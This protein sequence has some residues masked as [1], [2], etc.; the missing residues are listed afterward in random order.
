MKTRSDFKV[1]FLDLRIDDPL[2]RDRLMDAINTVFEHGRFILGPEVTELENRVAHYCD[3]KFA[4]GLGSGT[5]AVLLALRAHEVGP[6]DEV[7]TSA[8]SW[9]ATGT[10]IAQTGATPVFTDVGNDLVMDAISIEPLMS[11]RTKAIVPVHYTGKVCDM[12]AISRIAVRYGIPVIEDASQAFGARRFGRPAGSFG[13]MAAFSLNPM[14]VFA[15]CGEAGILLTDDAQLATTVRALRYNGMVDADTT[16]YISGNARIDTL[17]AAILLK[18][19]DSVSHHIERRRT[20]ARE[21][22]SAFKKFFEV[23]EEGDEIADRDA[24]YTYTVRTDAREDLYIHLQTNGVEAKIRDRYLL[25]DQPVFHGNTSGSFP[26]A[27]RL[28]DTLLC[29]P[30]HDKMTDDDASFVI[31]AVTSFFE[32]GVR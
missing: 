29:L 22:N 17:Q 20:I 28:I 14:K 7:I 25:S 11:E 32:D 5:D 1:P 31:S 6:G 30:L 21:Y 9:L 26:N 16:R 2:E 12:A 27:R 18:R 8:L 3:R 10:A 15:A 4:V 19:L 24:W 13:T 23:P